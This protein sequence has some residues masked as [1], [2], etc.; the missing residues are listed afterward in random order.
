M[1]SIPILALFALLPLA[2]QAQL[3]RVM[4]QAFPL[5]TVDFLQM[6]LPGTFQVETWAGDNVLTETK[7]QLFDASEGILKHFVEKGRY[8]LETKITSDSLYLFAVDNER[9]PIRT[10]KGECS[11]TVELRIFVPDTF[12]EETPN[13]WTRT[14]E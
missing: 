13:L 3:Q 1:R 6:D 8:R 5:D 2:G 11:E 10:L 7:I 4:H 9:K 14:S 12:E